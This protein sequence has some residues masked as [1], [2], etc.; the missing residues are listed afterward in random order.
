MLFLL[1]TI[2][3]LSLL[4]IHTSTCP[5]TLSSVR[6]LSNPLQ[7][8]GSRPPLLL[9]R[10]FGVL[11]SDAF[12]AIFD[13]MNCLCTYMFLTRLW[14]P[15]CQGPC[16]YLLCLLITC[17]GAWH[18]IDIHWLFLQWTNRWMHGKVNEG[19]W[20][21]GNLQNRNEL[22]EMLKCLHSGGWLI[23]DLDFILVN[24][25]ENPAGSLL[26]EVTCKK[27]YFRMVSLTV[28]FRLKP[29]EGKLLSRSGPRGPEPQAER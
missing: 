20:L 27:S 26:R 24:S 2:F 7:Q 1:S 28:A 15:F 16:L 4:T 25:M 6:V 18:I 10:M 22:G 17:R 19:T 8:G 13:N 9:V 11:F 21:E 29:T 12:F 23:L 5:W 14:T 3:G